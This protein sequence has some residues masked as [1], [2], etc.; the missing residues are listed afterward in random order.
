MGLLC[1]SKIEIKI[2][3]PFSFSI[4]YD[5]YTQSHEFMIQHRNNNKTCK[6][7]HSWKIFTRRRCET[8]VNGLNTTQLNRMMLMMSTTTTTRWSWKKIQRRQIYKYLFS[9]REIIFFSLL[10]LLSQYNILNCYCS[11]CSGK[12]AIV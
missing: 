1:C 5:T 8:R 11:Y 2:K 7:S 9:F 10:L 12:V 3:F 6:K 4:P